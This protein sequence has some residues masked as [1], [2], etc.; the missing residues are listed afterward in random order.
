M[1]ISKDCLKPSGYWKSL[2]CKI[3]QHTHTHTHTHTHMY[4]HSCPLRKL[5]AYHSQSSE[6][7]VVVAF[8]CVMPDHNLRGTAAIACISNLL[9]ASFHAKEKLGI[10]IR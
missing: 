3:L 5:L 10:R 4:I 8:R 7:E 6:L 2:E 1:A 9:P